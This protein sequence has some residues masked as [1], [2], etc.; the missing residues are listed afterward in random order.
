VLRALQNLPDFFKLFR[1]ILSQRLRFLQKFVRSKIE[2]FTVYVLECEDGK[3]YVGSTSHRK[4]R[5]RQHQQEGGG[6]AWTRLYKPIRVMKEYKRVPERYY[7]G[8]ESKV[9]AEM[10]LEKGPNNVRGAGFAQAKTY[11]TNDLDALTTFLGHYNDLNY[12][13]VRENLAV[14]LPPPERTYRQSLKKR[15]YKCGQ[16]GHIAANCP[17]KEERCFLCG[18]P[19]HF[20]ANCPNR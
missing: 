13:G 10:M 19:G 5:Y 15:C 18:E 20:A 17:K 1:S 3:Y 9:T 6:S 11:T 12:R 4:Q 14:I 16:F 2:G 7:L 8:L